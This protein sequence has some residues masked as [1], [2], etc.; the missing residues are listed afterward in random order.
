MER[1]VT[2]RAAPSADAAL[3]TLFRRM[4]ARIDPL[5]SWG[6]ARN[7]FIAETP[8]AAAARFV[9][10][11]SPRLRLALET[12]T[13]GDWL[14]FEQFAA[15]FLTVD[16]PGL[17]TTASPHGDRGRDGQ[18][19]L[20]AEEVHTAIQYSVTTNWRAKITQTLN[21]IKETIPDLRELLYVTN[22]EIGPAADDL[23]TAARRERGLYVDIRDRSWF[24]ERESSAPVRQIASEELA[25]RFVEPLLIE[26]GVRER[27][28]TAL[29]GDDSRIALLHLTLET[30]D[31][32]S[33]KGLTKS[34][35]EALVLAAL[36]DTSAENRLTKSAI[37]DR[38]SATLPAGHAQ[39]IEGQ[40][41]AALTRMSRRGGPVKQY[42]RDAEYHLSHEEQ[43]KLRAQ[44]VDFLIDEA[45]LEGE[46]VAALE[47]AA[48]DDLE[49]CDTAAVA[50]DLR[51]GIETVLLK[52]GEAFAR[53]AT[54]GIMAPLE[55]SEVLAAVTAAGR[56]EASR[57]TDEQAAA[58]IAAVLEGPSA[59]TH[60]HLRRLADAYTLFAFL[61]QTPDV[62]K[63]VVQMFSDG[64][65]WLDTSVLLPVFAETL[66]DE[67]L[68]R[69]YTITLRAAREAGLRLFVTD[70][71]IEELES[72]LYRSLRCSGPRIAEVARA[73]PFCVLGLL[74]FRASAVGFQGLGRGIPWRCTAAGRC[75]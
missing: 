2:R 60:A 34:C 6:R 56:S 46:L 36:H 62:Q 61:Q 55:P 17:R 24:V 67:P 49:G 31:V 14:V 26:R 39:Q 73:R 42:G 10:M 19:Y 27:V 43:V 52:K 1:H 8:L 3:R 59:E 51:R 47:A 75:A 22:Q 35:F 21:R 15:E 68:R 5:S 4:T 69:H 25:R 45:A 37:I 11:P 72:H 71:V 18:I 7:S 33:D 32:A 23:V 13:A 44:T 38:V 41:D 9:D 40:T 54:T 63:V 30:A 66:L 65:L 74:G 20:P 16:Y 29:S 57:L 12:M 28:A 50:S 58:A 70:G 48:S 64:D 53:A